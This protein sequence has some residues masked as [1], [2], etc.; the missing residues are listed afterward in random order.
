DREREIEIFEPREYWSIVATL[1]T[2]AGESFEA[3]LAGE[4]GRKIGRLDVGNAT[5]AKAFREALERAKFAVAKIEARP[6]RRN[7]QPPF[8]T[9][10]LQQEASRK[11]G[12]SAQRTM[13]VAQRLYEGVQVGSETVGLITYMRT[14]GVQMAD[15]AIAGIREMVR[16]EFGGRYL[17]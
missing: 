5:E 13:Q 11:L 12:F 7:P 3:R 8:T 16:G 10:T 17:P 1:A 14:D 2:P 4:N 15:E 9:S 6:G